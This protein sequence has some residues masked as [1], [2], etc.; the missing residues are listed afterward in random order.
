[1]RVHPEGAASETDE[2]LARLEGAQRRF[3]QVAASFGAHGEAVGDPAEL[4]GAIKRCVAAM[5]KGQA[6]VLT[7]RITPL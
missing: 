2:F 3:E 6:A 1:L 7:V 4:E 5:D